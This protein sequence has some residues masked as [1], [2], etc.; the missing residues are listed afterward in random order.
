[1]YLLF[2]GSGLNLIIKS[3]SWLAEVLILNRFFCNS[4]SAMV[5]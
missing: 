4:R 2:V 3:F 5:F 1:M